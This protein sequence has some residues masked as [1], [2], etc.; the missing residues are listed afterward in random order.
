M[1]IG[2]YLFMFWGMFGGKA[3]KTLLHKISALSIGALLI[4]GIVIGSAFWSGQSLPY[5][6]SQYLLQ[7]T[8]TN[9]LIAFPVGALIAAVVWP[10]PPQ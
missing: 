2:L 3:Q 4:G 10:K 5:L 7:Y 6:D 8:I 1:F 9:Y